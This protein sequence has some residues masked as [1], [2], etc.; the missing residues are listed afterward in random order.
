LEQTSKKLLIYD[1]LNTHEL[2]RKVWGEA[3]EGAPT[4]LLDHELRLW[5]ETEIEYVAVMP[6]ATIIGKVY[7]VSDK[8]LKDTDAYYT[9]EY[10]R[11]TFKTKTSEFE[12]YYARDKKIKRAKK[13]GKKGSK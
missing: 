13:K 2:Q 11:R 5:P 1:A 6:G 7:N 9:N 4:T 3:K 10:E 12:I 8:Q